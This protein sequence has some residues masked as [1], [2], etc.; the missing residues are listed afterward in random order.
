[1]RYTLLQLT[2]TVLSSIDGDEVNSIND[3]VESQQIVKIVKRVY[4]N[5]AE[6]S[7][8]PEQ[9]TLFGL[10]A[11]GDAT[12]PTVM[13]LPTD[14]VKNLQWVKYDCKQ[15][16]ETDT[17]FQKM[18]Y[19]D[20][21]EFFNRMHSLAPS[22]DTTLTTMTVTA[23][24]Q[25]VQFIV[26]N[27]TAP[28]YYTT[29]DDSTLI[30]NSYDS[31]VDTTLQSSK[32]LCYGEAVLPWTESDSYVIPIDDHQ[33]LLNEVIAWAWAELKQSSNA[34]A[35]REVFRQRI[36]QQRKKHAIDPAADYYISTPNYGRK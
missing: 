10:T 5:I 2:Q 25:S 27:D 8:Y 4:G 23:A 13:Y 34:K 12:L 36:V 6:A 26:Q 19:I 30:F 33:L 35:E 7:D 21:V 22:A 15:T 28:S 3:T 17:N 1:M 29:I 20:L 32:T 24:G 9:Y 16:G 11:S 31:V 14:T 18:Q